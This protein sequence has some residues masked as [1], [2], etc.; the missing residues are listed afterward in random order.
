MKDLNL[1]AS[2][3]LVIDIDSDSEV[4]ENID[5]VNRDNLPSRKRMFT[6]KQDVYRHDPKFNHLKVRT[7]LSLD[8]GTIEPKEIKNLVRLEYLRF[9]VGAFDVKVLLG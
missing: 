8:S 1:D 3:D 4:N 6:W 7:Y 9:L 5:P 2:K